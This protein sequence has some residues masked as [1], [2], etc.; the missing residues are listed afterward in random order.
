M[1]YFA[2]GY[3]LIAFRFKFGF[4]F[5]LEHE[6]NKPIMEEDGVAFFEG[7]VVNLPF[8]EILL[9]KLWI[10]THSDVEDLADLE[11]K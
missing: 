5:Y 9:G 6:D 1:K 2:D 7:L 10:P 3:S 8:F 11:E 4:G